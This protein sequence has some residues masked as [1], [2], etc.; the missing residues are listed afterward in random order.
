[1]R[2]LLE[3]THQF[4]STNLLNVLA[5]IVNKL[6][7]K[8]K[9]IFHFEVSPVSKGGTAPGTYHIVGRSDYRSREAEA[10]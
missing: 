9:E 6:G 4:S 1:M 8:K 5:Q 10:V 3:D 7:L 2:A